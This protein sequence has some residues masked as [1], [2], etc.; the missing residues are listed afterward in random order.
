MKIGL[1][2]SIDI[3]RSGL[4][5]ERKRLKCVAENIAKRNTTRTEN[6]GYYKPKALASKHIKPKLPPMKE[7]KPLQIESIGHLKLRP[8]SFDPD[9]YI[10]GGVESSVIELDTQPIRVF[11]PEHPDADES[12]HVNYPD[13]DLP[14]EMAQAI[15]AIRAYEANTGVISA[16]KSMFNKA[17]QI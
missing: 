13:I 6:G 16:A 8:P 10:P 1:F 2:Q 15:T 17:L 12:G 11:D 14:A 9:S 4:D 5:A 3:S 7:M